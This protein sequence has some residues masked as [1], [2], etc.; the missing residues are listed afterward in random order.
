M[1]LKLLTFRL[2]K[3]AIF[4]MN[5]NFPQENN[6]FS[7]VEAFHNIKQLYNI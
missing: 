1:Y 3:V 2:K 4:S 7:K 5:C 6:I